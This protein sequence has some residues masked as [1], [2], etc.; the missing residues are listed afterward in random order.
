MFSC[1]ILLVF[2]M[3]RFVIITLMV[4]RVRRILSAVWELPL[5][6][7]VGL[8]LTSEFPFTGARFSSPAGLEFRAS[9]LE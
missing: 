8:A 1:D 7:R 6:V 4:W 3:S 9:F 2:M 5:H